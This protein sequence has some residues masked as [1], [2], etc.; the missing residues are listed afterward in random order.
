MVPGNPPLLGGVGM[1]GVDDAA[2]VARARAGDGDAFDALVRP[3]VP[4]AI[5]L[6]YVITGSTVE[7]ED[8]TQEGLLR[9]YVNLHRFDDRA[10]FR[11]W[12][13]RI[14]ANSAKNRRRSRGRRDAVTVRA[15]ALRPIE[16]DALTRS[17]EDVALTDLQRDDVVAAVAT[18]DERDR[19]VV[20]YRYFAGLSEQET[21]DALGWPVGTVK[22]RHSRALGRLRQVLVTEE[23]ADD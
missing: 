5:R 17:G 7:A 20:A 12:L 22:S 13:M 9:A 4:S 14:V 6:A 16:H 2:H 10:P 23:V 8:A 21:A 18:L 3:L 19:M 1:G 11:P 15:A